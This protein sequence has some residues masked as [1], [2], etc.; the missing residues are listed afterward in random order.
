MLLLV[1]GGILLTMLLLQQLAGLSLG[2]ST[3][4]NVR[5]CAMTMAVVVLLMCSA[6]DRMQRLAMLADGP[7]NGGGP[8][9]SGR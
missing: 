8:E 2:D 1:G 3:A 7:S 9:A 5:R 4:K 6:V